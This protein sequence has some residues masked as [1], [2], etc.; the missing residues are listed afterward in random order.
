MPEVAGG[1]TPKV[2][3]LH[4]DDILN[5]FRLHITWQLQTPFGTFPQME[6]ILTFGDLAT[7]LNAIK[8][9]WAIVTADTDETEQWVFAPLGD[10]TPLTTVP[11]GSVLRTYI[12]KPLP[13]VDVGD[14]TGPDDV[15]DYDGESD[16]WGATP[17]A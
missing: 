17:P 3:R 15:E 10:F 16:D 14:I 4:F 6:E 5:Q 2:S 7:A 1:I 11:T 9:I 12:L 8:T 13:P